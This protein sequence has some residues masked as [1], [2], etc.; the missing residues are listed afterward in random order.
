MSL[1]DGFNFNHYMHKYLKNNLIS[2]I[3]LY[4][5]VSKIDCIVKEDYFL[6]YLCVYL[7]II[8][9]KKAIRNDYL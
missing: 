9:Q 8:N 1:Q 6:L 3:K 2:L 4:F 5:I 7:G